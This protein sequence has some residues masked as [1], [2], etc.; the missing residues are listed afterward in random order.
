MACKGCSHEGLGCCLDT[1]GRLLGVAERDAGSQLAAAFLS[2][3]VYAILTDVGTGSG[4]PTS[5]VLTVQQDQVGDSMVIMGGNDAGPVPTACSDSKGNTY[6]M[7]DM[8]HNSFG[9]D[10]TVWI[11]KGDAA[12]ARLETGDTITLSSWDDGLGDSTIGNAEAWAID[13]AGITGGLATV[14]DT[15]SEKGG[16]AFAGTYD[17]TPTLAA[18]N[19]I[20][21]AI[22]FSTVTA[23][24]T[25]VSSAPLSTE[26]EGVHGGGVIGLVEN[27][28]SPGIV[29]IAPSEPDAGWGEGLAFAYRTAATAS[30]LALVDTS[31]F[32]ENGGQAQI[33]DPD[34]NAATVFSYTGLDEE[35]DLLLGV[36]GLVSGAFPA[37]AVVQA[38]PIVVTRLADLQISGEDDLIQAR[39]PHYL[40]DRIPL[41][42]RD[43]NADEAYTVL[44]KL[45]VDGWVITDV[46]GE[47]PVVDGS[48]LDPTSIPVRSDGSPPASSPT[49]DVVA[50]DDHLKVRWAPVTLNAAGGPQIDPVHYDVHV[51]DSATEATAEI[52]LGA[53]AGE[54]TL[55]AVTPGA[56]GN[57]ITIEVSV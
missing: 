35:N 16:F 45:A 50:G 24:G 14:E 44:C 51:T 21:A 53:G 43:V 25:A 57:D 47:A 40:Y 23:G 54:W 34:T 30:Q 29:G 10:G 22:G 26:I 33:L 52:D 38:L 36:T 9:L 5:I 42:T 32:D 2:P 11:F 49:P 28:T 15:D 13:V 41:G 20:V 3:G 7:V 31:D 46:Y 17:L 37:G 12:A 8:K 1:E 56:A 27:G 18:D 39:I 55:T 19:E 6:Y 48:F 4:S